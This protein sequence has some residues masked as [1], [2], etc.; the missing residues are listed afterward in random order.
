MKLS[1]Q[2]LRS[3]RAPS[4]ARPFPA[5]A[6]V[7]AGG[8]GGAAIRNPFQDPNET[9]NGP[10]SPAPADPAHLQS[11]RRRHARIPPGRHARAVQLRAERRR[12]IRTSASGP[13]PW[14][15]A[16]GSATAARGAPRH[17]TRRERYENPVPL[18]RLHD[19]AGAVGAPEGQRRRCRSPLLG[20]A[21]W[22]AADQLVPRLEF[23]FTSPSGAFEIS[24]D[25]LS[26]TGG[27][28]LAYLGMMDVSACPGTSPICDQ[29]CWSGSAARSGSSTCDGTG[30]PSI[31]PGSA[32]ATSVATG[33]TAGRLPVHAAVRHAGVRAAAPTAAR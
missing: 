25:Y 5:P 33:R 17:W 20:T 24:A 2:Y 14:P 26:P 11:R 16:R 22:R 15:A 19:R 31:A 32:Y 13:C 28:D 3:T 4:R 29:P 6:R 27:T 1:D 12:S 10:F 23:P 8:R 30:E 21:P 9:N 18:E 7:P